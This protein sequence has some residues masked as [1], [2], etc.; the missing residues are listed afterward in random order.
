MYYQC[1]D[2]AVKVGLNDYSRLE[3]SD[4]CCSAFR[5]AAREFKEYMEY[6][7]L[8]YSTELTNQWINNSKEHW[9]THKVKESRKAM[10]V[11]ED[12]ME[13]GGVTMS[14]QTKIERTPPYNQLPNWS[15][16]ILD[17]YLARLTC[18]HKAS[19]LTQ[20]RNA[21]SRFFLFL[22][23]EGISQPSEITHGI[24]KSFFTKDIHISSKVKNRCNNEISHCLMYMADHGLVFKTVGLA[25]NKFV[26]P[27]L[28]IVAELPEPER[29][30][31]LKFFNS[32]EKDIPHSMVEYDTAAK[33]L[34]DIHKNRKYSSFIR[35]MDAQASRDFRVFMDAN[36]FS[37]SNDLALDWLEFQK[38]KWSRAKYLAFR[39][40][41]LSINEILCTGALTTSCFST[42]EPKYCLPVWGD[43]LQSQYLLERKHEGCADSTMCMIGSSCSRFIVFLDK[44]GIVS[45]KGITGEVIKD[46]QVHDNHSTIE[47]KNAYAVKIRGFLR[48]LARKGLIPD[49]L[50]LAVSTEMAPHN[51]IVTTLSDKQIDAI[52]TFRQNVD[53]PIKLRNIAIV[54]LGLRMGL[55]ASDIA[56]LKLTD[57]SWKENSI[58][59]IQQK[60]G[61]YLKL[62]LL[63]DAGNSLY[64]YIF[65]GRPQSNSCYVFVHHRAP[66]CKLGSTFGRLLRAVVTAQYDSEVIHG[67]HVTRKTFASKLLAAGSSVPSIA[68]A[69]GHVGVHTVDEYLA[70]NEDQMR[71]CAIGLKG[72][73]YSGGFSL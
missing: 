44:R 21:C 7:G 22:K 33:Q 20:I 2:E 17:N 23:F 30:R 70:T 73:E 3:Y 40:V 60:T 65:E 41:L 13:H 47:G 51:S 10:S 48:F 50:E 67:F 11:L 55:R 38:S 53:R 54:M 18:S 49:T 43:N 72:I 12:I 25:L 66:Y 29:N 71:L 24:V 64:R 59:F 39:R 27:D 45:E 68:A 35:K 61:V 4:S 8:S 1:Y 52:Y 37:Y 28:I 9:K 57:I 31:F 14:L 69:L 62:P 58:S 32:L 46:F 19:Y 26:I 5:V 34:A 36:S 15:R 16:T 56:N 42:H 63:V 6:R